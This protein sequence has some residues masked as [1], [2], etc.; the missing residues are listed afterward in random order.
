[1]HTLLIK[2]SVFDDDGVD[3]PAV[4]IAT[5]GP[6]RLCVVSS[7]SGRRRAWPQQ[8]ALTSIVQ[9]RSV[10]PTRAAFY[11]TVPDRLHP[12][13]PSTED[14]CTA[15]C[16]HQDLAHF[17]SVMVLPHPEPYA[18]REPEALVP[19]T[20]SRPPLYSSWHESPATLGSDSDPSPASYPSNPSVRLTPESSSNKDS[21]V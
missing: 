19:G 11:L 17:V 18:G 7:T 16:H 3:R 10:L 4:A 5:A 14:L 20:G 21:P 9:L 6:Q 1:M 15:L 12:F 8:G 13:D 2:V